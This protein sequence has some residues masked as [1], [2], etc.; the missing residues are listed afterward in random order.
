[1]KYAVTTTNGVTTPVTCEDVQTTA[2]AVKFLNG[3]GKA[4]QIVAYFA[5]DTVVS[6]IQLPE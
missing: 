5:A 1:M 4:A 3:K 6:V 2:L